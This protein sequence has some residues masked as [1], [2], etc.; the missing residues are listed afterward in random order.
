MNNILIT[1]GSDGLG[2]TI[3]KELSK[4]NNVYIV[5]NSENKLKESWTW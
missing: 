5:S 2:G 4:D 1:G 3:A